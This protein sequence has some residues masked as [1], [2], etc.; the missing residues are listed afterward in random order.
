MT[1]EAMGPSTMLAL[2]EIKKVENWS[3]AIKMVQFFFLFFDLIARYR[4]T[5]VIM[6]VK[7]K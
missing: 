2:D 4:V 3:K 5:H 7:Q 1:A 6:I